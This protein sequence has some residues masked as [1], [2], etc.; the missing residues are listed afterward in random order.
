MFKKEWV[1]KVVRLK[2]WS[3]YESMLVL[4]IEGDYFAGKYE[5]DNNHRR[6]SYHTMGSVR[7]DWE[8]YVNI[9]A[10]NEIDK[11]LEE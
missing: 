2:S 1:G 7:D 4:Y 5:Y 11:L 6:L 10:M 8:L 3:I 9:T